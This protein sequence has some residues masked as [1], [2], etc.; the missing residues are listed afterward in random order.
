MELPPYAC[1]ACVARVVMFVANFRKIM[2]PANN[3][4]AEMSH[5]LA[6]RFA[7]AIMTLCHEPDELRRAAIAIADATIELCGRPDLTPDDIP[8]LKI[9]LSRESVMC[10]IGKRLPNLK[11]NLTHF[12]R[13]KRA[14]PSPSMEGI[15]AD[16]ALMI[17]ISRYCINRRLYAVSRKMIHDT[18]LPLTRGDMGLFNPHDMRR[19]PKLLPSWLGSDPVIGKMLKSPFDPTY[20]VL[21]K[22]LSQSQ[23][24]LAQG[25]NI[26]EMLSQVL[27][28]QDARIKADV[29]QPCKRRN[30]ERYTITVAKASAICGTSERTF[31]RYMRESPELR[32]LM[33]EQ[34]VAVCCE[35]VK[36]WWGVYVD[37][38]KAANAAARGANRPLGGL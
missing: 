18:T 10:L 3:L 12:L 4:P 1:H 14:Q 30:Y 31:A 33:R 6:K 24:M 9:E 26:G 25:E 35:G 7:P 32:Q 38:T 8:D 16:R 27:V 28:N 23:L 20:E 29:M 37:G 36:R 2:I 15:L 34:S 5:F 17:Q 13:E 22:L 11:M 21:L 19:N